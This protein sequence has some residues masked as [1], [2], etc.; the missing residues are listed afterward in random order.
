MC[1]KS[2]KNHIN[3]E[4][5]IRIRTLWSSIFD[6]EP[7]LDPGDTVLEPDRLLILTANWLPPAPPPVGEATREAVLLEY[8]YVKM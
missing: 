3:L 4:R 5:R 6:V 1:S 8:Q 7:S 2:L